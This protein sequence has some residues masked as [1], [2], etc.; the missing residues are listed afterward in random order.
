MARDGWWESRREAFQNAMDKAMWGKGSNKTKIAWN[1]LK[2]IT[3]YNQ[4]EKRDGSI[5]T[6]AIDKQGKLLTG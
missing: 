1:V 3:G 5:V 2:R 4:Y 6:R